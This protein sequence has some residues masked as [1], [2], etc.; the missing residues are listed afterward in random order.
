MSLEGGGPLSLLAAAPRKGRKTRVQKH[1][2]RDASDDDDNEAGGRNFEWRGTRDSTGLDRPQGIGPDRCKHNH[3][4]LRSSREF[5]RWGD[6]L[7]LL[8]SFV[9]F[10]HNLSD[11]GV[12]TLAAVSWTIRPTMALSGSNSGS[13]TVKWFRPGRAS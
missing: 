11:D 2:G 8:V 10:A 1:D 4:S 3:F 5:Q 7:P 6:E 12:Q 13:S 9:S